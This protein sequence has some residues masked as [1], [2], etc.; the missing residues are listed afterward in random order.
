MPYHNIYY[1]LNKEVR[2]E[3]LEAKKINGKLYYYYSIWGWVNGK[4]RRKFQKYLGKPAD[5]YK[6]TQETATPNYAEVFDFGLPV[7][8]WYE[9][10]KQKVIEIIDKL[11]PKRSQGLSIGTYLG[12]A[13]ANRAINPTSKN[14]MWE[15]FQQT[16]LYRMLPHV[17]RSALTSQRFWD[18]MDAV[19]IDSIQTIWS[20]I[21]QG[22]LTRE[23]IQL[24]DICYDGTNFYT[25]INTFNMAC[26]LPKRGKN[27]QGRNNLRQVSY[28]LF[29]TAAEQIPLCFDIYPGN[30]N[31]CPEFSQMITRFKSFLIKAGFPVSH[32]ISLPV[33]LIFDKGNNSAENISFLD[34]DNIHFIGSVKLAEHKELAKVSNKDSR[35]IESSSPNLEGIKGFCLEKKVY[36][37][38]RKVV[39]CY[40][41]RLF[42]TQWMTLNN[43][44]SRAIE[45]LS[46]LRRRLDDRAKG[47]IK[48]GK[49]PTINS[50]KKQ[51]NAILKRPF[52]DEI[53]STYIDD[54]ATPTLTYDI[55]TKQIKTISDTYL[56]K[57]LI[58]TTRLKW[59]MDKIIEAYHSQYAIEH[60]FRKMKNRSTGIWWPMNHWTDQKIQVHGLYCTIATMLRALIFRRVKKAGI[61]I[62]Y[63]RLLHELC[64]I[65]EV[66]NIY[67]TKRKGQKTTTVLT[68]LNEIQLKFLKVLAIPVKPQDVDTV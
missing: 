3:R 22:T 5:I 25:F 39:I 4:C 62:S 11:C 51:V 68:K 12:I 26:T 19:P 55:D 64:T 52:L 53:I 29:C 20:T 50:V 27:K 43:D 18:H 59:N 34:Q 61:N 21:I 65:R 6:A 30:K 36:G 23:N 41:S 42:E 67:K 44:I 48:G 63:Q 37:K 46:D 31:D 16:A 54:G 15:W 2:M 9:L 14:N 10:K 40:N 56:G 35:F 66:V 8:L 58:I 13:A 1:T 24:E 33:T 17:N 47:L 57:K 60:V 38:I 49:S 28:A 7:A 45:K 32:E